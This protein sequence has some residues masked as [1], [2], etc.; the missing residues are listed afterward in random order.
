MKQKYTH[1]TLIY[2][3]LNVWLK[4][5]FLLYTL[6]PIA[7]II[8]VVRLFKDG[9]N[10]MEDNLEKMHDLFL[11]DGFYYSLGIMLFVAKR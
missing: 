7:W 11:E 10:W 2:N 8:H 9:H 1:Y 4:Y 6:V 5:Y 3:I